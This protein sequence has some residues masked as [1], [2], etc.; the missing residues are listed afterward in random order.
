MHTKVSIKQGA[1]LF[2]RH[3]AMLAVPESPTQGRFKVLHNYTQL[4]AILSL[5]SPQI[6]LYSNLQVGKSTNNITT[7][8]Q[9]C[10]NRVS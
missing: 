10:N 2:S 3:V 8:T 7:H 1:L 5:F 9:S 6:I 4:T